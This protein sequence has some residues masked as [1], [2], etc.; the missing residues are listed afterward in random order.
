M[1]YEDK[2]DQDSSKIISQVNTPEQ[3]KRGNF[4]RQEY[5][6]LMGEMNN[7]LDGWNDLERLY[8]CDRDT[9]EGSPNSFIPL[10]NPIIS[11]QIA[12][13]VEKNVSANV[14]GRGVSDH[15]F[16]RTGQILADLVVDQC[17]VKQLIK[18][19]ARDYLLKGVCCLGIAWDS[20]SFRGGAGDC[21]GFPEIRCKQV[22]RIIVDGKIKDIVDFQKAEWVIEEI[23]FKSINWVRSEFGDDIAN[24]VVRL[25]HVYPYSTEVSWDD[26]KS[27]SVLYVW[28]RNNE[29]NNL[30]RIVMD[31]RGLI[32][33]ESDPRIPFYEH[34]NNRYPYFFAGC[35]K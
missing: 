32:F 8:R 6:I 30:Q 34:V 26:M 17:N 31:K 22:N 35:Y 15:N 28:T 4:Y 12:S 21:V 29:Y 25:N 2:Y 19:I 5:W 14:K 10:V 24:S 23:G 27:T 3:V 18:D 7:R 20:D 1:I 13:L 11:G 33:S 9:I 16:A